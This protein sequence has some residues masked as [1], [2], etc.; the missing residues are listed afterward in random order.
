M[1]FNEFDFPEVLEDARW[2]DP[3][4]FSHGYFVSDVVGIFGWYR[5]TDELFDTFVDAQPAAYASRSEPGIDR[6]TEA[7]EGIRSH[8]KRPVNLT[9]KLRREINDALGDNADLE[10]WGTFDDLLK[11]SGEF[12]IDLRGWFRES[13]VDSDDVDEMESDAD[14]SRPIEPFEV[15][16]FIEYLKDYGH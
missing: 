6:M 16:E 10:W 3:R 14:P 15:E 4:K 12:E 11:G 5:T 2:R 7:L 8:V 1:D 9:E 13:Q